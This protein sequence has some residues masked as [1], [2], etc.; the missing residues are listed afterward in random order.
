MKRKSL[1]LLMAIVVLIVAF[2]TSCTKPEEAYLKKYFNA[3]RMN[4]NDTLSS[5]AAEP[6]TFVFTKWK[7]E[8]VSEVQSGPADYK[9][10]DENYNKIKKELDTLREQILEL[11]DNLEEAKANEK[12]ARGYRAKKKAKETLKELEAKKEE[13]MNQYREKQ[14]ELSEAK[15]T[16]EHWKRIIFMSL[17]EMEGVNPA[18][19]DLTKETKDVIFT[20]TTPTGEKKYKAIFIRYNINSPQKRLGRWLILKFEQIS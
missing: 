10:Y 18:E 14:K 13:L 2:M 6:V 15:K 17:G 16:L 19:L 8:S 11:N 4:D 7:V 5:M 1:F 9:T 12:K 20:L 3:I